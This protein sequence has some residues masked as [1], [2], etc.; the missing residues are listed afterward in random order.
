LESTILALVKACAA[1]VFEDDAVNGLLGA[2]FDIGGNAEEEAGAAAFV[3]VEVMNGLFGAVFDI[4][5]NAEEEGAVVNG[6]FG[7]A[8]DM[9]G[10]AAF[11]DEDFDS[12]FFGTAKLKPLDDGA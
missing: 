1:S 5:G 3:D 12:S 10:K 11:A 9:G 2:V 6:L 7:A 4:G 8:V